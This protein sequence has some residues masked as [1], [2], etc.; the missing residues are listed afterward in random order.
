MSNSTSASSHRIPPPQSDKL[1]LKQNV[2]EFMRLGNST[3]LPLFPY[4]DQGSILPAGTIFRGTSDTYYGSFEH[5]NDVDEVFI[6]FAAKGARFRS[7]TVRVG[8]RQH[9]VG[10]PFMGK[11][12][13]EAMALVVVTQRQSVGKEQ[14]EQLVFRCTECRAEILKYGFDSTPPARG[15]QVD[16]LGPHAPFTTLVESVKAYEAYNQNRVCPECGHEN[17]RFPTE[18]WGNDDYVDQSWLMRQA[19]EQLTR[20]AS[21]GG[22]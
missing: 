19:R 8:P 13:S 12:A 4:V 21:A 7:G 15:T 18:L 2:F 9:F 22:E 11:D 5:F 17:E 10:S 3:L 1:P 16:T 6:V 20:D 14:L